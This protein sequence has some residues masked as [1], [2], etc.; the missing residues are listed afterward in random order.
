M[1]AVANLVSCVRNPPFGAPLTLLFLFVFL[2]SEDAEGGRI[3][4]SLSMSHDSVFSP[5]KPRDGGIGELTKSME[6][7][8][9]P[10]FKVQFEVWVFIKRRVVDYL[11]TDVRVEYTLK[12]SIFQ[13]I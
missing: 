12:I 8:S 2:F 5:D 6:A 11:S 3:S 4:G 1:R 9:G 7:L 13:S 10:G